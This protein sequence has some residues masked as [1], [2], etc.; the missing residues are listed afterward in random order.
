MNLKL[1]LSVFLVRKTNILFSQASLEIRIFIE[2]KRVFIS[3]YE[4]FLE[5]PHLRCLKIRM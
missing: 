1:N 2:I 4:P 3:G 5:M